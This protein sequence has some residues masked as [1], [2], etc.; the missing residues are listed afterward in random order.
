MQ[1]FKLINLFDAVFGNQLYF[2]FGLVSHQSQ[3][4]PWSFYVYQHQKRSE[5]IKLF[6]LNIQIQYT[7]GRQV[8]CW[9]TLLFSCSQIVDLEIVWQ[10]YFSF[11]EKKLVLM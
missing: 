7:N 9:T 8:C 3:N 2:I 11:L 6:P 4:D 5:K 1:Q 10:F